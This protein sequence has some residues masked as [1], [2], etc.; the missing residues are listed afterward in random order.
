MLRKATA[1]RMMMNRKV[2]SRRMMKRTKNAKPVA[3]AKGA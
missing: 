1:G 2:D 3:K